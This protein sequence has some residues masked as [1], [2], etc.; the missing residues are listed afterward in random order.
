MID[1]HL[2]SSCSDGVLTPSLLVAEASKAG[3]SS[4]SISDHDTIA[5]VEEAIQAGQRLGVEVIPGVELSVSYRG[6]NDV[7]LLGYWIDIHAPELTEQLDKF[8]M[9]R[10]NRN[11]EIVLLVNKL[12]QDEGKEPLTLEEVTSLAD[13]VMGR[14]HIARALIK[15]SYAKTMEDA[16]TRYLIPSDVPKAYWAME[17]ALLTVKQVGGVSVLAHPTSITKDQ[18]LLAELIS[19]LKESGLDGL[20]VFNTLAT[21]EEI[22]FLQK[23]AYRFSLLPTGGS[24]FHG[25]SPDDRIGKG[26]GGTKFSDALLPP[27]RGLAEQRNKIKE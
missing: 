7:H 6:F 4:I 17:D 14:P 11:G 25:I 1:L 10:S 9:H 2:H 19:G 18:I 12:L 15:R 24:D 8:A 5:G 22:M 13:G 21:E 16:F 20:E 27:L 26:R 3:L 23:L